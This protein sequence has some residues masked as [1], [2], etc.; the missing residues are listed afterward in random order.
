MEGMGLKL[1]PEVVRCLLGCL[2][3][4]GPTAGTFRTHIYL[5]QW[6]YNGG[7]SQP[8]ATHFTPPSPTSP[9]SIMYHHN[10]ISDITGAVIKL[11]KSQQC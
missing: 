8:S 1:T 10:Y 7:Y 6:S 4:F 2:D 3:M 9:P 11:L 5:V